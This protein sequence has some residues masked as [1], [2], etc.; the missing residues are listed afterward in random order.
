MFQDPVVDR[1]LTGPAQPRDARPAVGRA[2]RR[3]RGPHRGAGRPT[4]ASPTSS[5]APSGPTAAGSAAGSRSPGPCVPR[6]QVLFL[7]EPTVGLD[8]RIRLRDRRHPRPHAP[9]DPDDRAAHDPLPRR[10]R[11]PVRP[12]RHHARGRRR[13]P[14]LAGRPAGAAWAP[15]SSTCRSTGP[16]ARAT[17]TPR[18]PPSGGGARRARTRSASATPSACRCATARSPRP[19]PPST[20]SALP[21]AR[22]GTRRPTLDDVY[23]RL[24][25]ARIAA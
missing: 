7:D 15:T 25:G 2:P 6:P 20:A 17:A 8:P 16:T 11:A 22:L 18:S 19:P 10:G 4:S 14:R 13:R 5:T 1:A 21:G 24:T 23:L 3:G 9:P 12:R